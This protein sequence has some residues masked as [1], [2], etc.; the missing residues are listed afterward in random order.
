MRK[1]I[2]IPLFL[3]ILLSGCTQSEV[4][5]QYYCQEDSECVH[6]PAACHPDSQE[7]VNKDYASRIKLPDEPVACTME[8]RP[9]T[10]CYCEDN[11]CKTRTSDPQ[12][13]C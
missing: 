7:C 2:L 4:D 10:E 9:C 12:G 8:C 5:D 1:L 11:T 3:V 6:L 13:C